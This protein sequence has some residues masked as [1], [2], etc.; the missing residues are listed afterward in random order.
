MSQHL[1]Q[2]RP[3]HR[4]S[5]R[6]TIIEAAIRVFARDG[7]VG[8]NIDEIAREAGVVP[9]AIY[10]H[11]SNK[12]KLFHEALKAAL[13]DATDR[14]IEVRPDDA[15]DVGEDELR[16]VIRAG[17]AWWNRHP[18]ASLL[19]GRYSKMSTA[20]ARQLRQAWEERHLQRAYDY[21]PKSA[22]VARTGKRAR[23]QHAA[24][25]MR[26]RLLLD[27]IL[28]SQ[29]ATL[30]GGFLAGASHRAVERAVEDVCARLITG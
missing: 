21:L 4:P 11:F 3:P 29:E 8:A 23:E 9:T 26:V 25:G 24:Y 18:N 20:Q 27:A 22:R 28:T 13:R 19:V 12:E 17:W 6:Q 5:R 2:H 15:H 7:Y 10:Y 30:P 16:R 14:V 1:L